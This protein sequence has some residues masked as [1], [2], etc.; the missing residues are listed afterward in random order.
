MK[1]AN[2]AQNGIRRPKKGS[3]VSVGAAVLF[4]IAVILILSCTF[5]ALHVILY[6][7]SVDSGDPSKILPPP[8]TLDDSGNTPP[9]TQTPAT[10][11]D[12]IVR[13]RDFYTFLVLGRDNVGDLTDVF[14][15]ISFNVLD[16]QIYIMQFPRDTYIEVDGDVHKINSV[17]KTLY[18]RAQ[19][20][21]SS[22]PQ[23]EGMRALC[24]VL[25]T[26]IN[27]HIDN[28]ALFNLEGFRNI[29]D[30]IGGVSMYV[31]YDMYY[32]DPDQDLYIDIRKG[33]QTLDGE[34]AEAF[35]RYRSGYATADIGRGDAQK[36]FISALAQQVRTNLN[37][38]TAT[39]MVS[40]ILQN[41]K[42]SLSVSDM[43]YFVKEFFSVDMNNFAF[44]TFPGTA[45]RSNSDGTG[46]WF[47]IM[48]RADMLSLLNRCFNIYSTDISDA[49]FDR[50][51]AFTCEE[52]PHIQELYNTPASDNLDDYIH[53]ASGINENGIAIPLLKAPFFLRI[54]SL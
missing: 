49:A 12:K 46:A 2:S 48:H 29:I 54:V 22:D 31:P 32:N 6:K 30:I 35:V 13:K 42:T 40:A 51:C 45:A 27:V 17:Y 3:R 8:D 28:Y 52:K 10:E 11:N 39:Q 41:V 21:N 50:S 7:P 20:A 16:K 9:V 25:E 24:S 34:K 36:M 18:R 47:Y 19:Y 14:M 15:L 1:K 23:D 33:Q 4:V 44:V 38:K 5:A 53:S 43:I 37:I 26:N